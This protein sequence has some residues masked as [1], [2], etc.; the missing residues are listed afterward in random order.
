MDE[1]FQ[2]L[3]P[4]TPNGELARRYARSVITIK[5]W[6]WRLGLRKSPEY[7]SVVQSANAARR[8]LSAEQRAHQRDI[9]RG[10]RMSEET[11]AKVMRTKRANGTIL[12]GARHPMWKGG[13]PWK[14]FADPRYIAWRNAVLSRDGYRCQMCGRQCA[15]TERGLAAHHILPYATNPDARLDLANGVTLCR[16]CHMGLHG[17]APRR[18]VR[19]RCACGCGT[20]IDAVDRYG[21]ARRYVNHHAQRKATP[22]DSPPSS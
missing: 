1:D 20:E 22:A 14:R 11:K 16:S 7:R 9:A 3:Y 2:R 12:R 10:R 8:R 4:T 19:I 17:R 18:S 6:A 13:H 15:K 5:K 21:R